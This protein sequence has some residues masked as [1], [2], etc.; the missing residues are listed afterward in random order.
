MGNRQNKSRQGRKKTFGSALRFFRPWGA[1]GFIGYWYPPLKRWAMVGHPCGTFVSGLLG[2]PRHGSAG[3]EGTLSFSALCISPV[4]RGVVLIAT[5]GRAGES[6]KFSPARLTCPTG[7]ATIVGDIWSESHVGSAR[8]IGCGKMKS[9]AIAK[10]VVQAVALGF[11]LLG[12][13]WVCMG[14]YAPVIGIRH[15]DLFAMFF[16]TPMF[17]ILGGIVI[18]VAWQAL[19]HFGPNA[20]KNV[21]GLVAYSAY[22]AVIAFLDGFQE[23]VREKGNLYFSAMC[24][25]PVLLAY[26]L[27]RVLSRKLI[28][29]TGMDASSDGL[30]RTVDPPGHGPTSA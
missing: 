23:A 12:L 15:S 5:G 2:E 10:F 28:E 29:M 4:V 19:R 18:A 17:L 30:N 24:L 27:Y 3:C 26:L 25:T 11:G 20:I 9:S 14:L 7:P 6:L 22:T 21:V 1:C 13:I 16:M 8:D